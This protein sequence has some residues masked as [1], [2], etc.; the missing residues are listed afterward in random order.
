MKLTK[1]TTGMIIGALCIILLITA[2]VGYTQFLAPTEYAVKITSVELTKS[3]IGNNFTTSITLQ[4]LGKNNIQNAELHIIFIKGNDILDTQQRSFSLPI[5]TESTYQANFID[6]SFKTGTT[7]KVIASVYLTN[8]SLDSK[9]IM[10]Q[11]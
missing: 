10:Q 6:I 5:G 9:S 2:Y 8:E 1:K 4:N 3:D 11:Y 7:Y